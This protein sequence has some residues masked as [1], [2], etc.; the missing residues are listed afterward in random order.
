MPISVGDKLPEVT[1]TQMTGD[2]PQPVTTKDIFGGRKVV[3][4]AVPGAFTPT[5]HRSHLPGFIQN[6]ATLKAKGVDAIVC[7][8]VNDV[9]VMDAWAKQTGGDDS[10]MFLAD[11]NADFAKAIGQELDASGFGMGIRSTRY[12]MIVD[13]GEVL[14]LNVEPQAG[15]A[16]VSGATA[17]LDQL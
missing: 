7:V 14:A 17:I 2:G 1:F 11:G 9:F 15:Q 4:F 3:M 8:S 13:D 12:S 5:C 10:I 6:A 16:E